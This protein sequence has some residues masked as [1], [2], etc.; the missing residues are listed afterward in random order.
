MCT[1]K[2]YLR[3]YK[4]YVRTEHLLD[5]CSLKHSFQEPHRQ[6]PPVVK[7][8]V[9]T[10][11]PPQLALLI[12]N[13]TGTSPFLR[14]LALFQMFALSSTPFILSVLER[15][16]LTVDDTGVRLLEELSLHAVR[17][18]V[19]IRP[20]MG[21]FGVY[22]DALGFCLIC[23]RNIPDPNNHY[24]L[25]KV[26][27]AACERA[28]SPTNPSWIAILG[29]EKGPVTSWIG[30][31]HSIRIVI[32]TITG[33]GTLRTDFAVISRIKPFRIPLSVVGKLAPYAATR[34]PSP[35]YRALISSS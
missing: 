10:N 21:Y 9:S 3:K 16:G 31:E 22:I 18:K 7:Y 25:S 1:S 33:S 14:H 35:P 23:N 20:M 34:S 19:F 2:R 27:E 8:F 29:G 30:V 28:S 17:Y 5:T 4:N 15:R 26:H 6:A 32:Q 24:V 12:H 11:I 13:G